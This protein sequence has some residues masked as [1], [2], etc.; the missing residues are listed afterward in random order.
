VTVAGDA[1]DGST[2]TLLNGNG[3]SLVTQGIVDQVPQN[4]IWDEYAAMFEYYQVTKIC[5]RFIPFR[6][7]G[8]SNTN[9]ITCFPTLSMLSPDS[10]P[11]TSGA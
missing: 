1:T 5:L 4:L 7:Q 10:I 11:A 2:I 6:Y 3:I 8:Q 9:F